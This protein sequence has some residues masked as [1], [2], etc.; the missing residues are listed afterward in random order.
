MNLLDFMREQTMQ[1]LRYEDRD[2]NEPKQDPKPIKVTLVYGWMQ[3]LPDNMKAQNAK[4]K[5]V[6]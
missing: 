4:R 5:G 2:P 1:H 3:E 6:E